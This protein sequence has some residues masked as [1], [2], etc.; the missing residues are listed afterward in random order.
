V[1]HNN[2]L[3]NL[4]HIQRGKTG[5]KTFSLSSKMILQYM[6]RKSTLRRE[7]ALGARGHGV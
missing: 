5:A 3:Q 2:Y 6:L 1:L 7:Y 4:N